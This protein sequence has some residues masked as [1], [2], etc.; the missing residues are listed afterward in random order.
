MEKIIDRPF[1]TA[2]G[3]V[4]GA[5]LPSFYARADVFALLS[6]EEGLA[7]VIAQA[8]AMGLPVVSTPNSGAGTILRDGIEGFIVP[9]RNSD[10]VAARFAA[11]RDE[12]LRKRMGSAARIRVAAGW[13]WKDYGERA[14]ANYQRILE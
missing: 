13:S 8:M 11:L 6:I 4:P 9:V 1:V 10:A 12:G 3:P 2:V 14:A 7:L 5:E